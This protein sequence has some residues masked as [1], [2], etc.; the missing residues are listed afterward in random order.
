VD[1]FIHIFSVFIIIPIFERRPPFGVRPA[2]PDP[3]A[4]EIE[5]HT[6]NGLT[7]RGSL[8]KP[9]EGTPKGLVIFCPEFGG[10]HW[11]AKWYC[12][13]LIENNFAVLS[14][15]FRNQGASDHQ[16]GYKVSHWLSQ[17]EVEDAK[18]AIEYSL[19]RPDLCDLKKGMFG[20]SRGGGAALTA[21]AQSKAISCVATEGAFTTD[22][23]ML[24][25]TVR[26]ATLYVP[27]WLMAILPDAH[28]AFTLSIVRRIS[29]MRHGCK[30]VVMERV[31][32]K[33]K[34]R[35]ILMMSGMKDSYV[36]KHIAEHII[37]KA[38]GQEHHQIWRIKKAKH[39]LGRETNAEV[40]DEHV[41]D[42]FLTLDP[43][44]KESVLQA[45]EK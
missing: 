25:F 45:A 42:F 19:S 4:E 14:F 24:Y 43:A 9:A 39:N 32:S 13:S 21:S 17:Y 23:L 22:S 3:N 29:Q 5:F 44:P 27:F 15:D 20:V 36:K 18:A 2:A 7:L 6:R 35:P 8:Y 40:Y 1:V 28:L 16:P 11:S 34:D 38:G 31:L 12:A 41:L 37:K 33:L 10:S 26:W 30:Y